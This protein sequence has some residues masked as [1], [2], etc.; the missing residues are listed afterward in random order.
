MDSLRHYLK[1]R[2]LLLL[3]VLVGLTVFAVDRLIVTDRERI[4]S[5]FESARSMALAGDFGSAVMFLDRDFSFEGMNRDQIRDAAVKT[6]GK[7]PLRKCDMM[8]RKIVVQEGG[9]A[10]ATLRVL[11]M[12]KGGSEL[13][14]AIL[15]DIEVKLKKLPDRTWTVT[16]IKRLG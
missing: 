9:T 13:E 12:G 16:A 8:D 1:I 15:V 7:Q 14:S 3:S 4:D 11:M 5:L 2:Y 10:V 6:F